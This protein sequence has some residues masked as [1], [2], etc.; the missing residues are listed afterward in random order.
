M[1][2]ASPCEPVGMCQRRMKGEDRT[3]KRRTTIGGE[4]VLLLMV[5]DGHGGAAAAEV[6]QEVAL[7]YVVAEAGGDASAESLR[8]ACASAFLATHSDCLAATGTAGATLTIVVVNETRAELTVANAGDS[9]ALLVEADG[10]TLLTAEHR[11]ADSEDERERVRKAGAVVAQ[12]ASPEGMPVGPLRA[13]PGGLAVCRSV[14]DAD[15]PSASPIPALR[16]V[17][18]D[19]DAGAA[20]AICSDGVWDAATH[21]NVARHVRCSRTAAEAADRVVDKAVRARGL[22]D[23]TSAVVAWLG[24]PAWDASL[25][26]SRSSRITRKIFGSATRAIKKAPKQPKQPK[27][28]A[29]AE[30]LSDIP[31]GRSSSQGRLIGVPLTRSKS[32]RRQLQLVGLA[33][34]VGDHLNELPGGSDLPLS[35]SFSEVVVATIGDLDSLSEPLQRSGVSDLA[36]DMHL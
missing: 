17:P 29:S 11:L 15:C 10:A 28:H 34:S 7:S 25:H 20:V 5:A 26:E 18:V 6:C 2:E 31:F 14:G 1:E 27:R 32:S 35:A 36:L 13:W 3:D 16:T 8:S 12:A 23:D 22:R 9:A 30:S 4:Q 24:V 19:M 33:G 21:G